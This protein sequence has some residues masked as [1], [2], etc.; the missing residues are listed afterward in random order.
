[1]ISRIGLCI[2][3]VAV[4]MSGAAVPSRA[5]ASHAPCAMVSV[6]EVETV[7]GVRVTKSTESAAICQ[8]WLED[9]RAVTLTMG[10]QTVSVHDT[11][12]SVREMGGTLVRK[13]FG[14]IVCMSAVIPSNPQAS[15]T[16]CAVDREPLFLGDGFD[17]TAEVPTSVASFTLVVTSG[18]SGRALPIED[19]RRL[20][21]KV[22]ARLV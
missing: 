11:E 17:N 8:R 2:I 21:Q 9:G 3:A 4:V 22:L 6:R 13:Q 12:A 7:I 1:M 15:R 10:H 19:V 5:G 16:L 14:D 18:P 20:A